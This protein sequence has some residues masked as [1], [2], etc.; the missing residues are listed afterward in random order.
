MKRNSQMVTYPREAFKY[1]FHILLEILL[2]Y[3]ISF[4]NYKA[5]QHMMSYAREKWRGIVVS[6]G[7]HWLNSKFS[8]FSFPRNSMPF[9]LPNRDP[10]YMSQ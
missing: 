8:C 10:Y 2:K 5:L 6:H 1:L 4:I 3:P 9:F 7:I